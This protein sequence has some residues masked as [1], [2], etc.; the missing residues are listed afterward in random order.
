[1]TTANTVPDVEERRYSESDLQ[2]ILQTLITWRDGDFRRRVP[3]APPGILSEIR[4]LL[5]EV[6]DRREHLANELAPRPPRGG[7]GGP[8]RRTPDRRSRRGFLGRER[9]FGELSDRRPGG[10]GQRRGGRHRRRG[11]GR[12]VTPDRP[13]PQRQGRGAPPRQGDQRHGRPALPLH[14]RGDPGGARGRHR[15]P[16]GRQ[17]QPARHVRQLARLDRGCQ[18]HVQPRLRAG[19]RHRAGDHRGREGR[20]EPQG[21]RRRRR[22]DVRAEEHRQHAWSTSFWRSPRRSPASPARS[23]PRASSAARPRSAASPA[24]GRTSPTTSTS[25]RAT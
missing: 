12:P 19:P 24:S 1:M 3:H 2:P 23:A 21:H 25:W 22:R 4:L 8:V 5:N 20:P 13:R 7:Q 18:H 9:R 11:Q 10:S 17:G 14:L 15:G 16:P 6:A